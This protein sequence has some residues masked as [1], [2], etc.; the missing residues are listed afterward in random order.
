MSRT[1][2]K[3]SDKA[4]AS[5]DQGHALKLTRCLLAAGAIVIA[6]GASPAHAQQVQITNVGDINLGTWIGSG[7]LSGNDDVCIHRSN[8]G[9]YNITATGNGVGNVFTLTNQLF[10]AELLS[11]QV[12][13]NDKKGTNGRV[14]LLTNQTLTGQ[15]GRSK[16]QNCNNGTKLNANV[17]I[18]IASTVLETVGAGTYIGTLTLLIGFD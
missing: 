8:K 2:A 17:S 4:S 9:D 15:K 1:W 3:A 10:A 14:E 16:N 5:R 12:F 13:W 6:L 18:E 11:Y 7:G